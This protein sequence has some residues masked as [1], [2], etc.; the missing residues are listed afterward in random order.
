MRQSLFLYASKIVATLHIIV[1]ALNAIALP[2]LII[3]EPFYIWMPMITVLCS[4]LIGGPYCMLNQLENFFRR[5]A[6]LES[7]EDRVAL[8][9]TRSKT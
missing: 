8:L 2:L 4:P 5:G 7:I 3:N 1:V 6:G 9:F